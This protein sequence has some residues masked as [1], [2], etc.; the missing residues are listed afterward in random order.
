[1]TQSDAPMQA[2]PS[3][4]SSYGWL[5]G[6][7]GAIAIVLCLDYLWWLKYAEDIRHAEAA[8]PQLESNLASVRQCMEAKE[9]LVQEV[10]AGRMGLVDAARQFQQLDQGCAT[11]DQRQFRWIY[12]GDEDEERYC[13]QVLEYARTHATEEEAPTVIGRLRLEFESCLGYPPADLSFP[14]APPADPE[15][16]E[17][18]PLY[19]HEILSH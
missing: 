11:F 12:P 2:V 4:S 14:R 6:C 10:L 16:P 19:S 5:L 13:Y 17:L 9:A 8:I 3:R 1:M 18:L 15:A 7:G